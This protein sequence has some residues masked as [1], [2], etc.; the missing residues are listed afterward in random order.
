MIAH[1]GRKYSGATKKIEIS[2]D[3]APWVR[4]LSIDIPEGDSL[5][6]HCDEIIKDSENDPVQYSISVLDPGIQVVRRGDSLVIK[7]IDTDFNGTAQLAVHY[8][9]AMSDSILHHEIKYIRVDVNPR[10]CIQG[11]VEDYFAATY[12]G[13]REPDLVLKPPFTGGSV[14]VDG[15]NVDLDLTTGKFKSPKL[16]PIYHSVRV[17]DFA[18]AVGESSYTVTRQFFSGD[19]DVKL[20]FHSTAGTGMSRSEL[21]QFYWEANFRFRKNRY[22]EGLYAPDYGNVQGLSDYLAA[23]GAVIEGHTLRGFT[24]EQQN[25]LALWLAEEF[26][27][28]LPE[29]YRIRVVLGGEADSL[30]VTIESGY[31]MPAHG[32]GVAFMESTPGWKST[33]VVFTRGFVI[34]GAWMWLR[35]YGTAAPYGISRSQAVGAFLARRAAPSGVVLGAGFGGKTCLAVDG[36]GPT[37]HLTG[38]D[39]KLLWLPLLHSPGTKLNMWWG[40]N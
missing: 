38:A 13:M 16:K 28:I 7:G 15:M 11:T 8:R 10:D 20:L 26:D 17:S 22:V 2:F 29:Q 35:D 36:A 40:T 5:V 30:P 31:P 33:P 21:R 4:S 25:I 19:H 3:S 34:D 6:L 32:T 24:T 9:Y 12:V 14:T 18:N 1:S 39:K 37:D 27:A 23:K